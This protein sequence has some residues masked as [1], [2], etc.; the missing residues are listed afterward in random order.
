MDHLGLGR[1]WRV[2]AA[3]LLA[4]CMPSAHAGL[5]VYTSWSTLPPTSAANTI[6]PA[7]PPTGSRYATRLTSGAH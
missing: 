3:W 4:L 7:I 6:S 1:L 2:L 5:S